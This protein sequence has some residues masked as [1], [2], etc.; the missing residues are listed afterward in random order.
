MI[1]ARRRRSALPGFRLT[2]GLTLVYLCLMVLIPLS[3]VFVKSGGMV[4]QDFIET[5]TRPN[6]VAAFKLSLYTSLV[7]ALVNLVFGLLVAWVLVRYKFPGRRIL[8]ALVDLPFALPTAVAGIVLTTLYAPTG[9]LGQYLSGT[10]FIGKHFGPD[11]IKV[12]YEPLGIIVA[13]VF[14]GIPFVVR[15]VQPVL[16]DLDAEIEEAS[17][18]LGATRMQTF[19]RVIFPMI[20]PALLTGFALAFA[21]AVG[22]YGSVVFIS[23][24][25][26]MKTEIAPLT[27]MS[28]LEQY[29][30]PGAT[31]IALVMLV[32]SFVM[33]L[34]VNLLQHWSSKRTGVVGA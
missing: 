33:L 6:V 1:F 17:A 27:I 7:A 12:A 20:L 2:M 22:E 4:R 9:W 31:A 16:E 18:S 14:I 26:P 11:G 34:I 13:L 30:V 29:N 15:T 21:R 32:G 28:E 8:D 24:N 19:R 25:L 23:G 3:T 5:I 10:G